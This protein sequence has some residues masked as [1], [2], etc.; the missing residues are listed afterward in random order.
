MELSLGVSHSAA[1]TS[2]GDLYTSG[3]GQEGQ[4]GY[5]CD[6]YTHQH[7]VDSFDRGNPA[8]KTSCGDCYTLVLTRHNNVF[9]FGKGAHGRLG[10]GDEDNH[11]EP[12]L[13]STLAN[14][15]IVEICAGCRHAGAVSASGKLYTWGFNFYEQLGI[16]EGDRDFN[17]PTL[18]ENI[19]SVKKLA[20]GY[21]HSGVLISN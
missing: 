16:G 12:T 17:T 2:T 8:V 11:Y 19:E 3:L 10:V 4:L 7:R 15:E 14:E 20:F 18:V 21:F 1:I 5:V 13:I 9:A 6:S